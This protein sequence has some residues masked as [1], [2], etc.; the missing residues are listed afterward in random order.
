VTKN[1]R[2]RLGFFVISFSA[3]DATPAAQLSN[4]LLGYFRCIPSSYALRA[5]ADRPGSA[6]GEFPSQHR[7]WIAFDVLWPNRI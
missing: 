2:R 3:V 4:K 6:K 5:T 1:R 7:I